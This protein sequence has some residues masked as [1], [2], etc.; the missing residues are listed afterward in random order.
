M[1]RSVG[2]RRW[3]VVRA[4]LRPLRRA[5]RAVLMALACAGPP[6]PAHEI[7]GRTPAVQQESSLRQR[8]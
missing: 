4:L 2:R 6:M 8:E 5:L 1:Y 7:R 3:Y